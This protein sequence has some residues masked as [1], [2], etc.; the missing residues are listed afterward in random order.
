[1]VIVS[2]GEDYEITNF[3]VAGSD[4]ELTASRPVKSFIIRERS[5]TEALQL[6]R[7]ENDAAYFPITAG[8]TFSANVTRGTRGGV[9]S[10]QSY[11]VG[12]VRTA[13]GASVTVVLLVTY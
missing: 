5:D 10:A 9:P 13:S 8:E 2:S 7:N 4:V 1:M 3:T 6:R 12:W 11:T